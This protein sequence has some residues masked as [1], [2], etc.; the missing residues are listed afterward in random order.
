MDDEMSDDAEQE[1]NKRIH[2]TAPIPITLNISIKR[3]WQNTIRRTCMKL[4]ELHER[5]NINLK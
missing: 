4:M 2:P 1:G 5:F 3:H